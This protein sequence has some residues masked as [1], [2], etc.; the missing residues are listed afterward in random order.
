[1]AEEAGFQTITGMSAEAVK[2]RN[3]VIDVIKGVAILLVLVGHAIQFASGVEYQ[4]AGA[5]YDNV[6]FKVIYSF[7]MPL[8]MVLSG[9]LFYHTVSRKSL[10]T[11]VWSK[12]RTLVIPIFSFAFIVWILRFN[13]QYSIIDQV[14]NYLSVTRSTLWFLWTLFYSSMGVLIGN[15]LFKDNVVVWLV[16]IF[17]SFLTPDKWFSEMYKFTFPCFLFGYYAHKHD[18]VTVL[19][20]NIRWILP[21]GLIVFIV[22]LLFYGVD[23]FVYMSGSCIWSEGT[24]SLRLLWLDV[25]RT[26]VGILGSTL[27]VA[28]TLL[29]PRAQLKGTVPKVLA[30]IGVCSM[31]IYC[32]QHF[33]FLLYNEWFQAGFIHIGSWGSMQLNRFLCLSLA[34][35]VSYGLTLVVKRIKVLNILFLGGR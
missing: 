29:I 22:C 18:W 17:A 13:P 2:Q 20:N 1:M 7:H 34:F 31:G 14:R 35:F 32:F 28:F 33:Y 19:K 23:T 15:K 12:V 21:V 11:I 3:P 24:I 30:H 9:Y 26:F 8:F 27:F 16:L 6:L 10:G 5:F 25:F 4:R